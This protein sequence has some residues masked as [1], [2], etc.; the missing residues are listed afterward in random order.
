MRVTLDQCCFMLLLIRYNQESLEL[1]QGLILILSP[2]TQRILKVSTVWGTL[3]LPTCINAQIKQAFMSNTF[4]P[5]FTSMYRE[6]FCLEKTFWLTFRPTTLNTL[7]SPSNTNKSSCFSNPVDLSR[8]V[9]VGLTPSSQEE[10][11]RGDSQLPNIFFRA[12]RGVS[13]LVDAFLGTLTPDLWPH[14][15]P[16]T[17][18]SPFNE[19]WPLH[20][21][22]PRIPTWTRTSDPTWF[23]TPNSST[24]LLPGPL[25]TYDPYLTQN[26][27]ALSEP[28]PPSE[29]YDPGQTTSLLLIWHVVARSLQITC[30]IFLLIISWIKGIILTGDGGVWVIGGVSLSGYIQAAWSSDR[31]KL[32]LQLERRPACTTQPWKIL[33]TPV[34]ICIYQKVWHLSTKTKWKNKNVI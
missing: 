25:M 12:I 26:F 32:Y 4:L 17:P 1:L 5:Q 31:W 6:P 8:P 20:G 30:F 7:K 21:P 33:K 9:V 13:V 10:V 3:M 22:G 24:W 14:I 15:R 19:L 16:L 11:L 23:L 28:E 27:S 29:P 34:L 18:N 2:D